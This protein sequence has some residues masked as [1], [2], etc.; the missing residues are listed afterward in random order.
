[1]SSPPLTIP[2]IT[3][4]DISISVS[5]PSIPQ[6]DTSPISPYSMSE[7]ADKF[8]V[9]EI[10][11]SINDPYPEIQRIQTDVNSSVTAQQV[12][13]QADPELKNL[14]L[15]LESLSVLQRSLQ[16]KYVALN[17]QSQLAENQRLQILSL[18]QEYA[19]QIEHVDHELKQQYQDLVSL[20][21]N[22]EN[23]SSMGVGDVN[24]LRSL[25]TQLAQEQNDLNSQSEMMREEKIR[26]LAELEIT[27][28]ETERINEEIS[29]F[30]ANS[31]SRSMASI[32]LVG[33]Q[34]QQD[35]LLGQPYNSG[36]LVSPPFNVNPAF[37]GMPGIDQEPFGDVSE[38][39]G[40]RKSRN[41]DPSLK[42]ADKVIKKEKD[43]KGLKKKK[44]ILCN[45]FTNKFCSW[46]LNKVNN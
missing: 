44:M 31:V 36:F 34:P 30:D 13:D 5:I 22:M 43:K 4:P 46:L 6:L 41:I 23:Y 10:I 26:V 19:S 20:K 33:Q 15:K 11:M 7:L 40:R 25:R 42:K 21:S 27:R 35:S 37:P 9:T 3:L 18:V 28:K 2:E 16:D 17:N 14:N 1:V 8:G 29:Q 24:S 12:L 38:V 45:L 39:K 32:S